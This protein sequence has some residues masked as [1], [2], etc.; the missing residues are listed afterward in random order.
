M[1]SPT[2][3]NAVYEMYI[4][5][6]DNIRARSPQ[7]VLPLYTFGSV[8]TDCAQAISNG[9]I[10]SPLIRSVAQLV[11]DPRGKI[12]VTTRRI[13]WVH[14]ELDLTTNLTLV[15]HGSAAIGILLH[16]T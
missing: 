1:W 12:E 13:C 8:G 9:F 2:L 3:V 14:A 4:T 7:G 10:A 15:H 11:E 5:K 6:L 16:P